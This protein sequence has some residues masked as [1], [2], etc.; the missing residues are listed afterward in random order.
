V[1]IEHGTRGDLVV[2][3]PTLAGKSVS[4]FPNF[5]GHDLGK[6]RRGPEKEEKKGHW[7]KLVKAQR[8]S[9][10]RPSGTYYERTPPSVSGGKVNDTEE[11]TAAH[12][13]R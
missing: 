7:K 10:T 8:Q 2:A 13:K 3:G 5:R 4:D 9:L 1:A 12:R 11:T 6:Q